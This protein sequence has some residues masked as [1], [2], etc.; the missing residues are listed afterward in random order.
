MYGTTMIL[1]L[2]NT[3]QFFIKQLTS[4]HFIQRWIYF[5]KSQS[6]VAK[7]NAALPNQAESIDY[8][9]DLY[10][11]SRHKRRQFVDWID[12]ISASGKRQKEWFFSV[13]A[14]KNTSPSNLYLYI[15][16]FFILNDLIKK[17]KKVDLV[18]VD[19]P[20]LALLFKK[21]FLTQIQFSI[22]NY[23]YIFVSSIRT[24]L[25]SLYRYIC[26]LEDTFRKYAAARCILA[27]RLKALLKDKNYIVI[28][29]NFIGPDFSYKEPG[30]FERHFFPGL[31]H[32]LMEQ[33]NVTP[34]FL[35][36]VLKSPSYKRLFA[37]ILKS[38]KIIILAEEFLKFSDYIYVMCSWLRALRYKFFAPLWEGFEFA[39]LLKEEYYSNLTED[40]FLRANLLSRLGG[41]FK[42]KGIHPVGIINWN[43]YQSMEKGLI[44]G[45]KES[46]KDLIV[47][48]SQPFVYSPGHLSITPSRQD[49]LFGCVPH[50][51][52]VLGPIGREAVREFIPDLSIAYSPAFRYGKLLEGQHKNNR[53]GKKIMV[54]LGY[55]LPNSVTI[56]RS[57]MGISRELELFEHIYIRLHPA[58]YFSESVLIRELGQ[59]LPSHYSFA[60]GQLE[61]YLDEICV[62]ICGATG[63]AVN[64]IVSGIP[65]IVIADN[66][67]LTMNY[68]SYKEDPHMWRLC[69]SQKEIVEAL[70]DF[71]RMAVQE[72]QRFDEKAKEF[73]KAYFVEP[74]SQHWQNYLIAH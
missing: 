36:I 49:Q 55:A 37:H 53:R 41:R 48:G 42:G 24:F 40:M 51:T 50:K 39:G 66:Y 10:S 26:F 44:S 21:N 1:I 73:R 64:L 58:T 71:Y 31:D 19:S 54:L 22:S 32:Y 34:V 8:A 63:A 61:D 65:I 30:N 6:V 18:V 28:I 60:H 29:R 7:V 4:K 20:A 35:P 68:L 5:G 56:L 52:L 45:L 25:V 15:C 12:D 67:G 2:S 57:L 74:D 43:E 59:L 16:Y 3:P 9:R 72:P 38:N 11:V 33:G 62:G 13:P 14:V 69:F 70:G 46:F 47:I 27:G 23:F 17:G